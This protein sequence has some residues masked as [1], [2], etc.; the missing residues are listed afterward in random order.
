[1]SK[2]PAVKVKEKV[3]FL[4]TPYDANLKVALTPDEVMAEAEK[5]ARLQMEIAA[6]EDEAASVSKR[7][8]S[9]IEGLICQQDT[10]AGLVRDKFRFKTVRCLKRLDWATGLVTETRTDTCT[11]IEKREMTVAETQMQMSLEENQGLDEE[12]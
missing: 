12:T 6:K 11:V 7:Y 2:K 8:K 10:C 9:E 3:T 5:M 1:M 4:E